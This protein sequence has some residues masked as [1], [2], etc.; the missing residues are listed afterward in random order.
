[1]HLV[2]QPLNAQ[3]Q[4][5]ETWQAGQD[6]RRLDAAKENCPN[7]GPRGISTGCTNFLEDVKVHLVVQPQNAQSQQN[8]IWQA[9][10]NIRRLETAN[11]KGQHMGLSRSLPGVPIS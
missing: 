2:M 5:N 10:Q 8:E 11:E 3:S 7:I 6:R 4:K 1:V 9:V